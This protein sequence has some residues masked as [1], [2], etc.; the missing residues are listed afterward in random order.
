MCVAGG[1]NSFRQDHEDLCEHSL[2]LQEGQDAG[3]TAGLSGV[4]PHA[5]PSTPDIENAE[6]TSILPFLFLGN[7][8][9]AQNL[10][11]LQ[12]LDI[13]Y[14]LNVTTHL[15]LYHYDL[16][17]FNYKRLPA[18]DSNKQNLHQYFEEAF[19]FIGTV[20]SGFIHRLFDNC[21]PL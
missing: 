11:Q 7:E 1:L 6:L 12:R 8:R 16:S 3:S 15:P 21:T 19:E 2:H 20:C 14:I 4:L 13:S 17:L 18:T 10:N 5:L 9:D